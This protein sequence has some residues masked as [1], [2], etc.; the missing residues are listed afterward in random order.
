MITIDRWTHE[1]PTA[2]DNGKW[3]F[4][5]TD[6]DGIVKV[7]PVEVRVDEKGEIF[8]CRVSNNVGMVKTSYGDMLKLHRKENIQF[9]G[10]IQMFP[11]YSGKTR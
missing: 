4:Q 3:F 7:N 2:S 8:L 1:Q 6:Y 9:C 11:D 5:R 10:P